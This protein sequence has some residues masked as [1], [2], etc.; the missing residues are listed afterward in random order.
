MSLCNSLEHKS[1]TPTVHS[2]RKAELLIEM[3]VNLQKDSEQEK[4]C[5]E[6]N[7]KKSLVLNYFLAS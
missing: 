7:K 6:V 3:A 5:S 4:S 1:I 2:S